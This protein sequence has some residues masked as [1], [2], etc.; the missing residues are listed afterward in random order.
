MKALCLLIHYLVICFILSCFH[1]HFVIRKLKFLQTSAFASEHGISDLIDCCRVAN[2]HLHDI[3]GG[4]V[5]VGKIELASASKY[6][7][8]ESVQIVESKPK[9]VCATP[10]TSK[11][12]ERITTLL[13]SAESLEIS[14]AVSLEKHPPNSGE[15]DAARL[16]K[17]KEEKDRQRRKRMANM[18]K[19][20][21]SRV[22]SLGNMDSASKMPPNSNQIGANT[23]SSMQERNW[24][25]EQQ[26]KTAAVVHPLRSD[27][28]S[29]AVKGIVKSNE[30]AA[31]TSGPSAVDSGRSQ[32]EKG[33]VNRGWGTGASENSRASSTADQHPHSVKKAVWG[34]AEP[35]NAAAG[36]GKSP[37]I[38]SDSGGGW[39][40]TNVAGWGKA[41]NAGSDSGGGW[42]KTNG[43]GGGWGVTQVKGAFK[44]NPCSGGGKWSSTSVKGGATS[45]E[46]SRKSGEA[47]KMGSDFSGQIQYGPSDA[48]DNQP[49]QPP[50]IADKSTK[51]CSRN[52][53]GGQS[54]RPMLSKGPSSSS[55]EKKSSRKTKDNVENSTINWGERSD[56]DKNS[57][58]PT[59]S[60]W[61]DHQNRSKED[62]SQQQLDNSSGHSGDQHNRWQRDHDHKSS[63]HEGG[64]ERRGW[65]TGS[66][67]G[68]I[69]ASD[70]GSKRDGFDYQRE[71]WGTGNQ[72]EQRCTGRDNNHDQNHD[73]RGKRSAEHHM[74]A[75][76]GPR[77]GER[78]KGGKLNK[79]PPSSEPLSS[80]MGDSINFKNEDGEIASDS[81]HCDG[82]LERGGED[83]LRGDDQFGVR[84]GSD[85]RPSRFNDP[86]NRQDQW[87]EAKRRRTDEGGG[88]RVLSDTHRSHDKPAPTNLAVGATGGPGIGR[89][90][91]RGRGRGK[92]VNLPAW[93]TQKNKDGPSG[94]T[95]TAASNSAGNNQTSHHGASTSG[96]NNASIQDYGDASH[97]DATGS[98]QEKGPMEKEDA[99]QFHRPAQYHDQ[100]HH[101]RFDADTGG[102]RNNRSFRGVKGR[103]SGRENHNRSG[104]SPPS[105][106][107]RGGPGGTGPGRGGPPPAAAASGPSIGR[108]RGRG[109]G[110]DLTKPAWMTRQDAS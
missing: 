53:W 58:C 100:Q 47:S 81:H 49:P 28:P 105:R 14:A 90:R 43:G 20:A 50:S 22:G 30:P 74:E 60:S 94:D 35:S 84:L 64:T 63:S 1:G 5:G 2:V 107:D 9:S 95:A 18:L 91:G 48:P 106:F 36:W 85:S 6:M 21:K 31:A 16:L 78:W 17:E 8:A 87:S 83:N 86:Q 41:S 25:V 69:G 80:P 59:P 3:M 102:G 40:K 110:R 26:L 34:S 67:S 13:A 66:R 92:D 7:N 108:G 46:E 55:E 45:G 62:T 57:S 93:M 77:G 104:Q 76:S 32:M 39:S 103:H 109:R 19:M 56:R 10:A 68:P 61:N 82:A 72:V 99:P 24:S 96:P 89:G 44:G 11:V 27:R 75:D 71:R 15:S 70:S 52:A 33:D 37:H 101:S 29:S 23:G 12:K 73:I 42:D 4:N 79:H 97:G 88:P 65:G 38:V 54:D 98:R 51:G